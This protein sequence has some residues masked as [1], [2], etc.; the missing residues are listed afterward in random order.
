MA[1]SEIKHFV[2]YGG[3]NSYYSGKARPAFRIKRAWT[4]PI[5]FDHGA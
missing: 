2:Y 3:E 1:T 4:S 5:Q